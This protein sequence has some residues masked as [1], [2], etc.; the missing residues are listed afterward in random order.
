LSTK[1]DSHPHIKFRREK[2]PDIALIKTKERMLTKFIAAIVAL[3]AVSSAFASTSSPTYNVLEMPMV[4]GQKTFKAECYGIF[5]NSSSCMAAAKNMCGDQPVKLLQ[6]VE[7]TKAPGNAHELIF[8]C[9]ATEQAASAPVAATVAA[10]P[11]AVAPVREPVANMA[12]AAAPVAHTHRLKLDEKTNFD[13]DSAVLKPQ[14]KQILD[15]FIA[16]NRSTRPTR[17]SVAGY[18]D[19]TGTAAYN[20]ALSQRRA[21]TVV[22]YLRS[23]GLRSSHF[24]TKGYGKNNPIASN[25]TI[26]GRAEN[27]RVEIVLTQ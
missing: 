6:T 13:F 23:R 3:V 4:N 16:E 11:V 19:S 7:G 8:N 20:F 2:S 9:E 1:D 10:T 17:V 26:D 5:E 27:R 14:A 22:A 12:A 21:K 24:D 15:S 25:Q 18:T